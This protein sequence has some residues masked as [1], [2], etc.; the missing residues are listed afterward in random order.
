M[1]LP[2][3]N[4]NDGFAPVMGPCL[5]GRGRSRRSARIGVIGIMGGFTALAARRLGLDQV[6][7]LCA[8]EIPV[9]GSMAR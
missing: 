9:P 2:P 6:P 3:M 7:F 4:L 5:P 8:R 1:N